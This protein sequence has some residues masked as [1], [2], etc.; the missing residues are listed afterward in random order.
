MYEIGGGALPAN[1][2]P[3]A[4]GYGEVQV[5][6]VL[7]DLVGVLAEEKPV[8]AGHVV[9]A[10]AAIDRVVDLTVDGVDEVVA[11]LAVEVVLAQAAL[12]AIS[13]VAPMDVVSSAVAEEPV[14]AALA[15]DVVAATR[16]EDVVA[17]T[18]AGDVVPALGADE[19]IA[20]GVTPQAVRQRR[21]ARRHQRQRRRHS[22]YRN[23][24]SHAPVLLRGRPRGTPSLFYDDG[25]LATD[26]LGL[27]P[28]MG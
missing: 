13:P 5:L 28:Q 6:A 25:R 15:E 24:L 8:D 3:Y 26:T 11:G 12:Q 20:G 21:P 14:L 22:E 4:A 17:A 18:R 1:S 19:A 16:A 2:N 7:G 10:L 9:F 27:H 23:P